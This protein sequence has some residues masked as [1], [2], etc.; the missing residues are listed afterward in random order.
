MWKIRISIQ[1]LLCDDQTNPIGWRKNV[2]G[3]VVFVTNAPSHLAGL[4][5]FPILQV[6][7]ILPSPKFRSFL[8]GCFKRPLTPPPVT[9]Y[10]D[11]Y[12]SCIW[13]DGL[14]GGL[15]KPY[16]HTCQMTQVII[17]YKASIVFF[18]SCSISYDAN[19]RG[20]VDPKFTIALTP[21]ILQSAH[22]GIFIW[23]ITIRCISIGF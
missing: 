19:S 20:K 14:L 1:L 8:T 22:S 9:F 7:I 11:F 15:W 10:I 3:I 18:I 21:T 17:W 4:H 13:G 23:L 2:K 6:H 12:P 16:E 5:R